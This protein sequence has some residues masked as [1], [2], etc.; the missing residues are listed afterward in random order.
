LG[1]ERLGAGVAIAPDRVLTAHYLVLGASQVQVAGVDGKPRAVTR[2]SGDHET[3]LGLL[4]LEGTPLR[5]ARLGTSEDSQPGGPVFLRT[6]DAERAR[7]GASGHVSSVG[8]F[9]AFWE[10][11]LDRAIMT[12]AIN[13]GL[14]GAPLF[15]GSGRLIGLVCLGV[16]AGGG[17]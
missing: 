1:E 7:K 4:A 5:G 9:E 13:P 17:F 6:C 12:T 15:D 11:R 8:P 10:Y 16:A 3:G 14:A 2:V